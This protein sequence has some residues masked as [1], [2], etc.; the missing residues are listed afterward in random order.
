MM[1]WTIYRPDRERRSLDLSSIY[2]GTTEAL[3]PPL[4]AVLRVRPI[5]GGAFVEFVGTVTGG[6]SLPLSVEFSLAPNSLAIGTHRGW[7]VVTWG[8]GPRTWPDPERSPAI[9]I[10]VQDR[11]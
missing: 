8:D 11:P 4:S 7:V 9:S 3:Q 2:R 10:T 6:G 1:R 5:D